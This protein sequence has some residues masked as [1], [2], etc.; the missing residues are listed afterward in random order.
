MAD[1]PNILIDPSFRKMEE[2]FNAD[3]LNRLSAVAEIHWA[4]NERAPAEFVDAIKAELFAVVAPNNWRYGSLDDFPKLRAILDVGGGL[5]G[6]KSL[7]YRACF[8]RGIRVLTCAPAFAPMVAEM[9]LGM[10]LAASRQIVVGHN[11]FVQGEEKYFKGGNTGTFTLYHQTVGLIGFG[12]L[13]RALKP[14]LDPFQCQF[15]AYDPWLPDHFLRK[16]GV[17]PSSL[18]ELLRRSKV[19]FVLAVPSQENRAML[20]RDQLS[21]IQP[22]AILALMSRAHLVDFEALTDLVSQGKFQAVID[23]FPKEPLPADH[24]IRRASGVILS[25][26]RAGSVARDVREIGRMVVDDLISIIAGIP[27]TEMQPAEP[28]LIQR[29]L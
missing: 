3:D 20:D 23:V 14:L 18:D 7:D 24:P 9:A 1:K 13:A 6:P 27:P 8:S 5:P 22:G 26:H 12:S 21:K 19:I 2:I 17:V 11:A 16:Q 25:A 10:V 4:R 28:E 29:L 15:L